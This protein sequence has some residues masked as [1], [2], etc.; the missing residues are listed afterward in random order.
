MIIY[1]QNKLITKESV[2]N[3]FTSKAIVNL[4][5]LTPTDN[6]FRSPVKARQ[7]TTIDAD[8]PMTKLILQGLSPMSKIRMRS[9]INADN[10][11]LSREITQ[12]DYSDVDFYPEFDNKELGRQIENY[13]SVNGY[14]PICGSQSLRKF[15]HSNVPVIDL[16]CIN[17]QLHNQTGTTRFFQVK[18][19]STNYYFNRNHRYISVGSRTYAEPII[20]ITDIDPDSNYVP[21]YICIKII[22]ARDS[23]IID[24]RNSFCII[25]NTYEQLGQPFYR[26]HTEKNFYGSN[27]L[28]WNPLNTIVTDLSTI[29]KTNKID[30]IPMYTEHIIDNPYKLN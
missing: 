16:V 8:T 18:L 28:E 10:T 25:P 22:K 6:S 21:G 15:L 27:I 5:E 24:R 26:F 20:N 4:T 17:S 3:I 30:D 14:C 23:Y 29:I 7:I 13:L 2:K 19:S 9:Q 11:M 12:L 1:M